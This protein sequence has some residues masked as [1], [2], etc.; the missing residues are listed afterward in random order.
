MPSAGINPVR[1]ASWEVPI[2]K[3]GVLGF[4]AGGN[5]AV[6]TAT[7]KARTY[8][9]VDGADDFSCRPDFAMPIYPAS[10]SPGYKSKSAWP[11]M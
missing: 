8:K 3:L 4:S 7:F 11:S 2:T 5:L 1:Q 9:K 10:I 6:M